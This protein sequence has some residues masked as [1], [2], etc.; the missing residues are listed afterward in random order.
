MVNLLTPE[1]RYDRWERIARLLYEAAMRST[2]ESRKQT[3][4]LG[5]YLDAQRD[6][7]AAALALQE[8]PEDSD[9]NKNL[10]RARR[11]LDRAREEL[12]H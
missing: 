8:R 10:L 7:E 3:K 11:M 2:R 5:L 1:Q 9:T 12:R 4:K 6:Y